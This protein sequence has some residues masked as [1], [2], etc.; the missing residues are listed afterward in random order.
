MFKFSFYR[1]RDENPTSQY[2][3]KNLMGNSKSL[4]E[5][6]EWTFRTDN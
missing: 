3:T 6:V 4:A 1:N 5:N 2:Y